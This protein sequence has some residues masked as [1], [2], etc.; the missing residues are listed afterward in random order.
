MN[1]NIDALSSEIGEWAESTFTHTNDGIVRHLIQKAEKL[2]TAAV[3]A[4]EQYAKGEPIH[5]CLGGVAHHGA[6]IFVLLATLFYRN[7]LSLFSAVEEEHAYNLASE[8]EYDP[9]TDLVQRKKSATP[10]P[11][12]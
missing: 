4:E 8:W 3:A 10:E 6:G 5:E 1:P 7:N 2:R 12:S 11:A 9:T